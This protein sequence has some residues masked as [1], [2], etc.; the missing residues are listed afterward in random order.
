MAF[1]VGEHP[2][3][4]ADAGGR[5][6]AADEQGLQQV[7]FEQPVAES[8]SQ[9]KWPNQTADG[10]QKSFPAGFRQLADVGL[11]AHLEQQQDDADFR[12]Q[13]DDLARLQPAQQTGADYD[14]GQQFPHHRRA[15]QAR[16]QLGE[17]PGRQQHHH[18]L[19]KENM[20]GLGF[21]KHLMIWSAKSGQEEG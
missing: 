9:E 7:A 14:A 13:P 16:E 17:E 21:H 1:Q 18:Q 8:E 3:G 11:Q 2:H 4:D 20:N 5:Q 6:R 10:D 15:L 12:L 19:Q